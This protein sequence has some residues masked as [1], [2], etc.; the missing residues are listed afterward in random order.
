MNHNKDT[1]ELLKISGLLLYFHNEIQ[2]PVG[3]CIPKKI[4]YEDISIL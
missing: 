3:R 4:I 1:T 2:R